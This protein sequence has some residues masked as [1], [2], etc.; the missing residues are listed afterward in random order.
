MNVLLF[1]KNE[2]LDNGLIRITDNR[3]EH[4]HKVLKSQVG[5]VLKVGELGGLLGSGKIVE[6]NQNAAVLELNLSKKAP[7]KLPLEVVIAL[8]RPAM[9]RRIIRAAAELG[10]SAVHFINSNRVEK[11]Y[12]QTPSLQADSIHQLVVEGLSQSIDTIV[13]A[14]TLN[15]RFKPFVEDILPQQ[16]QHRRAIALH[17]GDYPAC[18]V[19][20][21]E[22]CTLV[23]GPEG[24]FIPYE[25][26][27]LAEQGCTIASLGTRILRVEQ[28]FY[29]A[30]AR[31]SAV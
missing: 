13:P 15:P 19:G 5:D 4:L 12:W 28:A 25:I 16:I 6:L 3:L 18:P 23:I 8:P 10:V 11:S 9:T 29:A 22:P 7:Q 31:I 1:S 26:D 21:I 14:I 2:R 27:L 24:G 17:P 30:I 20:V